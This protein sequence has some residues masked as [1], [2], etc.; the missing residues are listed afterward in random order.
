MLVGT[1]S[2]NNV[3]FDTILKLIKNLLAIILQNF[4]IELNRSI[5]KTL[6]KNQT[7]T[8][9]RFIESVR[10]LLCANFDGTTE[11]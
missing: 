11:Q 6:N 4:D 9:K 8:S 7:K 10:V 3:N 2:A 5:Y 1:E